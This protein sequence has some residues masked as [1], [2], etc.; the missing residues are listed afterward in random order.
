MKK[1]FI[2]PKLRDEKLFSKAVNDLYH[3]SR[4]EAV[5]KTSH[6]LKLA[7]EPPVIYWL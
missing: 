3:T 5:L 2:V 4:D 1:L 7:D 6:E